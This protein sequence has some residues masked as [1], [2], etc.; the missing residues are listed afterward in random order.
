MNI[1]RK[2]R[3]NLLLMTDSTERA[4]NFWEK[5]KSLTSLFDEELLLWCI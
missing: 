1:F 3:P 4:T 2:K 5:L